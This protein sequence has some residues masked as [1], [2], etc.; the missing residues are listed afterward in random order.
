MNNKKSEFKK[1]N[2]V[3]NLEAKC[4]EIYDKTKSDI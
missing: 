2:I 1:I 4:E 3:V